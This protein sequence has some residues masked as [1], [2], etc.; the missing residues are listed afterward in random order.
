MTGGAI[1]NGVVARLEIRRSVFSGN[2]GYFGAGINNANEMTVVNSTFSG[3]TNGNYAIQSTGKITDL[4]NVTIVGNH[5]GLSSLYAANVKNT[6]LAD[7][8]S[9]CGVGPRFPWSTR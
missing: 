5:G 9:N 4:V 1:A 6:I 3:N 2:A 7:N 8:V